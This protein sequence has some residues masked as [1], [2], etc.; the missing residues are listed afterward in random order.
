MCYKWKLKS[1]V[2]GLPATLSVSLQSHLSLSASQYRYLLSALYTAFSVP[3]MVLPLY[4]GFLVQRYGER[5]VLGT[6]VTSVVM[7][8]AVFMVGILV[9]ETSALI[10][11]RVIFGLGGEVVGVLASAVLT[12]HFSSV[13]VLRL[14]ESAADLGG[15]EKKL[16]LAMAVLLGASRMGSVAN[17]VATPQ[18]VRS[19]GV[20][21]ATSIVITVTMSLT[22]LSSLSLN[23]SLAAHQKD[24][25]KPSFISCLRQFPLAFW[26][27]ILI[28]V[29]GYGVIN[30]FTNS[31]QR[32]LAAR[33]FHNDQ[34]V[35]GARL[36]YNLQPVFTYVC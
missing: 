4:S 21:E 7:G 23:P 36:R 25:A 14:L 9:R 17:S 12:R 15:S 16:P 19:L 34:T 18:F 30:T 29:L 6:A 26:Q 20:V 11:S 33:F 32:F 31:A 10:L 27:L 35:A 8:Q 28:C 3:N 22:T 1:L 2:Y 24:K 5:W 13:M